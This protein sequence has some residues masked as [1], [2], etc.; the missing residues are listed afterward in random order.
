MATCDLNSELTPRASTTVRRLI[1]APHADDEVLGC[2]GLLAKQPEDTAVVVLGQ[3]DSTRLAEFERAKAIL[4][5]DQWF[6]LGLEDGYIGAD[7]HTLVG[8]LDGVLNEWRPREMYLPFPSTHQDHIS[9]FEAGMRS[10]RLSMTSYHWFTPTV[11]VYDVAAYD[12][13]L[14]PS[15]LRWNVFEELS[16]EQVQAKTEAVAAYASQQVL[17]PHPVNEIRRTARAL[18][19][20]RQL[21]YAEQFALV[22]AVR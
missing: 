4:G 21:D 20:T 12:L 6:C 15:D 10:A 5:Y 1:V 7:M 8:K 2:G 19:A 13:Q 22:R 14:Y 17:G 16:E 9:A 11:L 3:P 18:G